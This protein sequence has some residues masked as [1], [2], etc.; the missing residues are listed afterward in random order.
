M[1]GHDFTVEELATFL[2]VTPQH[3]SKLASRDKLPGR[4]I[5]GQWHFAQADIHHWME[6]HIG[7]SN[8]DNLF[9]VETM[10]DRS[11]RHPPVAS[12]SEFFHPDAITVGLGARTRNSVIR[13]MCDLA[14]STGLLWDAADMADAVAARE[15]LHP[16]ALENGVAMLHPRRPQ[17]SILAQPLIAVGL[18]TQ[19]IPFG[20]RAGH[21]TDI[22]F[23]ICSTDD[24]VHLRI[25]TR[26]SRLVSDS[27]WLS[28]IRKS[29][30]PQE[31]MAVIQ[32]GEASLLK[33]V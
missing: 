14:A 8:L 33:S 31:V 21:L 19:P 26:L 22:F 23:L 7:E 29:Q 30:S 16:T 1:S 13:K 11:L 32:A 27:N 18:S 4:R 5:K 24:S 12:V 6:D 20:N 10:L 3:V 17:T 28:D 2:H 15:N 25:L 9:K